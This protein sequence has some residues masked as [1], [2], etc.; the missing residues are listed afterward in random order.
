MSAGGCPLPN[1]HPTP[2]ESSS[3]TTCLQGTMHSVSTPYATQVSPSSSDP[4]SPSETP[5]IPRTSQDCASPVDF[6]HPYA[7]PD[8]VI[9]RTSRPQDSPQQPGFTNIS[10]RDSISTVTESI[11]SKSTVFPVMSRDETR[12]VCTSQNGHR[13]RKREISS[14]TPLLQGDSAYLDRNTKFLSLHP[15]PPY[16]GSVQPHSPTVALI[17]LQ[18]AQARERSRSTTY[19]ATAV[20]SGNVDSTSRVYSPD[21]DDR[22]SI[23]ESRN[24]PDSNIRSSRS[25]TMSISVGSR[26][27]T[28]LHSLVGGVLPQPERRSSE[29]SVSSAM[30]ARRVLKH[31]K[32]GFMRLFSARG[33]GD[34]SPLPPVPSLSDT[35]LGQHFQTRSSVASSKVSLSTNSVTR[36]SLPGL[37][38]STTNS[39]TLTS[40]M[41]ASSEEDQDLTFD[42][43]SPAGP[44]KRLPPPLYIATGSSSSLSPFPSPERQIFSWTPAA[45]PRLASLSPANVPQSAPPAGSDFQGLKLR[46]VSALFSAQFADFVASPDANESVDSCTTSPTVNSGVMLSPLTPDSSRPSDEELRPAVKVLGEQSLAVQALQDRFVAAKKAWQTQISGLEGQ[47]RDLQTEI[48]DLRAADDKEYCQVCRRGD[49]LKTNESRKKLGVLDRP[50]ARTSDAA[51]FSN[52]NKD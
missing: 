28:T 37:E 23:L 6:I 21:P 45:N 47:V 8:L 3:S 50:R 48:A 49:P 12:D 32:S 51:R 39:A 22:V 5:S 7:N 9:S 17:S 40:D 25:R 16:M 46:P 4:R 42:P 44:R 52:G 1:D 19:H 36:T 29:A 15:P 24:G 13:I 27:K 2:R 20:H 31:K 14:P 26:A 30:P 10:R 35:H 43:K 38:D 11:S 33:E 18:E 34:K 41:D